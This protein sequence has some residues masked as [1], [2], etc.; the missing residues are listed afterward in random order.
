ML[1][2]GGGGRLGRALLAC[3][4]RDG[5][6]FEAPP[7]DRADLADPAS[8]ARALDAVGPA[9]VVNAAA[10]T[11]VAAC[12]RPELCATVFAVNAE[13]PTSLARACAARGARLVHVSTDYVFDGRKGAPYDED[14]PPRPLQVYGASK[15]EGE[16][17]V[18][19]TLSGALVVRVST[20]FGPPDPPRPAYVDHILRQA[21]AGG[22]IEVV[23]KPVSSPTYAPDA[24]EAILELCSRGASGIVHVVNAGACSRLELA[25]ATVEAA[26]LGDRCRVVTRPEPPGTLARPA[27][28]VLADARL[29]ALIGRP[30]RAWREAVEAY[31]AASRGVRS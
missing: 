31:V 25:R 1:V 15:L 13:G 20:L 3:F 11:D 18:L 7:I 9:W 28:S 27:Y 23:E 17:G 4:A 29:R 8:L 22:P 14:D 6:P 5:T 10:F 26:G 24:A 12:E 19:D 21:R 30:L 2:L 16:R